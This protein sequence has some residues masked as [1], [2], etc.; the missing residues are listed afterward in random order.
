MSKQIS[1]TTKEPKTKTSKKIPDPIISE[2]EIQIETPVKEVK[3]KKVKTPKVPK[4]KKVGVVKQI[5]DMIVS[6]LKETP[7]SRK[8]LVGKCP[9]EYNSATWNTRISRL[10]AKGII[11]QDESKLL[12]ITE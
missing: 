9:S 7:M 10:K 11:T 4:E 3:T 8:D 12:K 2:P 1:K 6:I 5:E